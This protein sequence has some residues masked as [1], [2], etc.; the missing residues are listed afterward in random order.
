MSNI[1]WVSK[2]YPKSACSKHVE[3]KRSHCRQ[4]KRMWET[5]GSLKSICSKWKIFCLF[6]GRPKLIKWE[7]PHQRERVPT[8]YLLSTFECTFENVVF[9]N[10]DNGKVPV[11]WRNFAVYTANTKYQLDSR[12]LL[13]EILKINNIVSHSLDESLLLNF[14]SISLCLLTTIRSSDLSIVSRVLR[15]IPTNKPKN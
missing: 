5:T 15:R 8:E 3:H 12:S 14:K 6:D 10:R 9:L 4:N 7:N 1:H 11:S 13:I 2:L